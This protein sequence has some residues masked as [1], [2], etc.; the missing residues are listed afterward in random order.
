MN[1]KE[2]VERNQLLTYAMNWLCSIHEGLRR[3]EKNPRVT[4]SKKKKNQIR[5]LKNS[6]ELL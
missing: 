3:F 2:I 1:T 4:K 5:L 6:G